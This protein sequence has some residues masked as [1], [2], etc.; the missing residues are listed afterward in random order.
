M[1]PSL[2]LFGQTGHKG[3]TSDDLD[4]LNMKWLLEDIIEYFFTFFNCKSIIWLCRKI[5]SF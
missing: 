2:S 1:T 3:N 5:Y 4:Y